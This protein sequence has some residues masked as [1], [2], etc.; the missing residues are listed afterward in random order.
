MG[1]RTERK[2]RADNK[3]KLYAG[4]ITE[5]VE[6]AVLSAKTKAEEEKKVLEQK[7]I[8][9]KGFAAGEAK[10]HE[11]MKLNKQESSLV[12]E[13]LILVTGEAK[14]IFS[15]KRPQLP[16][17]PPQEKKKKNYN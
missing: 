3:R 7:D 5:V 2:E 6:L 9:A 15:E 8:D 17:P 1:T 16:K 10:F 12:T 13:S 4:Q 14:R 11:L